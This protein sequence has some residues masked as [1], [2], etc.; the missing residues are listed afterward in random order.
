MDRDAKKI[1]KL[2]PELRAEKISKLSPE[3]ID[4]L[5]EKDG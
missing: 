4:G 1:S 3:L 2:S 5:G